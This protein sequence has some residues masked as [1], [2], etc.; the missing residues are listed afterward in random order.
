MEAQRQAQIKEQWVLELDKTAAM[1]QW[2]KKE[3]VFQILS[4]L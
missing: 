1:E 4:G 2:A 3:Q